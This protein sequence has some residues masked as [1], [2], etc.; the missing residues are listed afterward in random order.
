LQRVLLRTDWNKI[1]LLNLAAKVKLW[2]Q[3]IS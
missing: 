3:K 1:P 2:L